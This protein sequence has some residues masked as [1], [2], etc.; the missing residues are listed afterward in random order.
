MNAGPYAKLI[1]EFAQNWRAQAPELAVT[2]L[3]QEVEFDEN[4]PLRSEL[5]SL[6][7]GRSASLPFVAKGSVVVWCTIAPDYELLRQAVS[8]LHAW[9]LPS[10]GGE[11]PEDGFVQSSIAKSGLAA[12]IIAISPDGYY[13]WR[14]PRSELLRICEKLQLRGSLEAVRP[15]RSRPPRPSLYELRARFAAALLVGDR[16]GAESIIGQLD[17]LQLETAVNTQF[18]RIR[19]WHHFREFERIREHPDLPHLLVQ[20]LPP[21][22]RHWLEEALDEKISHPAPTKAAEPTEATPPGWPGWFACVKKGEKSAAEV[23]LQERIRGVDSALAPSLVDALIAGVEEIY[24]DDAL[25]SR[26][27]NLI[28]QGIA[29][30]LEEFVRE[31]NFP[32]ASLGDFYLALLRLWCSLHAGISVGQEHGHV[33]LELANAVL[34]LNRDPEAVRG[35]LEEWWRARPTPSQLSYALDAIELLDRELPKTE[36]TAN[37]WLGAVDVILRSPDALAPSDRALWRNAG[38]RLGFTEADVSKYLPP[39]EGA[40]EAVD[41]LSVANLSHIAIV[42]LREEQAIQAAKIIQE[43]TGAKVTVVT[44]QSAGAETALAKQADVVL[45]VWMASTHAVFR[46]FDRFDK[47]RFC[48]VQGTGFSSIVRTLE[49]WINF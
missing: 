49:R 46:A 48:Y 30:L 16:D 42:C 17:F 1:G 6:C 38:L 7:S 12:S 45:F 21:R 32:R 34:Q 25:R 11:G 13:R 3:D 33:L 47:K 4:H 27:R 18:M 35:L 9:V 31:P 44:S 28:L 41:P 23:F 20:P 24:L 22:V 19:M 15:P 40:A 29:E 26:E 5:V 36:A 14:C 39:E 8:S 43:R 10:F 37:L 2:V